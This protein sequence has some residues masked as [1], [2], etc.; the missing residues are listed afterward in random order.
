MIL[1]Y[2]SNYNLYRG[3]VVFLGVSGIL[4]FLKSKT[5]TFYVE[6]ICIIVV[7]TEKYVIDLSW[8]MQFLKCL[9]VMMNC[10]NSQS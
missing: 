6:S 7:T 10:V 1:Y 5:F 3:G 4:K 2:R 9:V 8:F